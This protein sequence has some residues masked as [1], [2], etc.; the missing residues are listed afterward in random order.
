MARSDTQRGS[1]QL[2]I[3][4]VA[5]RTEGEQGKLATPIWAVVNTHPHRESIAFENLVRQGF[6]PY[7]PLIRR[8]IRHA[9][10]SRDVLRPLFPGYIFVEVAP[11]Q[12]WQSIQST[13]GVRALIQSG[14]DIAQLDAKFIEGLKAREIDGA[15]IRPQDPYKIGETVSFTSGPFAGLIARILE[16]E[17]QDRIVLLLDLLNQPVKVQ[18][19]ADHIERR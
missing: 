10:R 13:F 5:S 17:S 3:K 12:R 14:P 15:V 6:Q 7:C 19:A 8:R 9:R 11:D 18:A 1:D 2:S 16:I 4:S